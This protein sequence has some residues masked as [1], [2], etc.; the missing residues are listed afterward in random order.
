MVFFLFLIVKSCHHDTAL[1]RRLVKY[2]RLLHVDDLSYLSESKVGIFVT[3][4]I[5][6]VCLHEIWNRIIRPTYSKTSIALARITRVPGYSNTSADYTLRA[7]LPICTHILIVGAISASQNSHFGGFLLQYWSLLNWRNFQLRCG[8]VVVLVNLNFVIISPYFAIS[9]NVVH[10]LEPV[11]TPSY[12][13]SQQA[14]K[15]VQRS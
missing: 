8:C 9:K 1:T 4:R 15:Y 13:A 7:W 14:P 12:S 10:S 2:Y 3:V 11:E 6:N 5:T